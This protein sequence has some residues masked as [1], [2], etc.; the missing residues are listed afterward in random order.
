MAKLFL[1][2]PRRTYRPALRF[3]KSGWAFKSLLRQTSKAGFRN[4]LQ[5]A[6]KERPFY[7]EIAIKITPKVTSKITFLRFTIFQG[8]NA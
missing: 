6:K 2:E 8:L 1:M 4:P 7:F 5:F 3:A